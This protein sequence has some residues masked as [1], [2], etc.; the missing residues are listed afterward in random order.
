LAKFGKITNFMF[1]GHNFCTR[2][3]R[4][5]IKGSKDLDFSLVSTKNLSEML[6]SNTGVGNLQPAGQIE[7]LIWHQNFSCPS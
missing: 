3:S 4:K 5:P 7:Y 6:P 2:N 1:F